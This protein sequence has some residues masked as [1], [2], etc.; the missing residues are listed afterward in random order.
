MTTTVG[1]PP[2][3]TDLFNENEIR[4]EGRDKVNGKMQYTA[5]IHLPNMLWSAY[6]TSPHAYARIKK[7]DTTAAK[8]VKGV[9]AV[10]T[11]HDIGQKRFG[12][13]IFDWPVLCYDVVRFIGDRVAAIAAET[14][15]AADEAARL[16]EVE[17]E[18]LDPVLTPAN[19]VRADAP[20]LHPEFE[21]YH[22]LAY[23]NKPK[24]QRP[25]PNLQTQVIIEKGDKDRARSSRR[26][27]ACSS[28]CSRRRVNTAATSNRTR[29]WCGSTRTRP[30]TCSRRTSRRLRCA[31]S[32]R[33]SPGSRS[34]RSSSRRARSAVTSAARGSRSTSTRVIFLPR[35]RGVRSGTSTSTPRSCS[36]ST[37]ATR[38][39]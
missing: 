30:S 27:T 22:Y 7:I 15:E 33:T 13:Q 17:Y 16:V 34:K 21:H 24:P 6:T 14:R 2:S 36:A 32:S 3:A 5:D 1:R 4:D 9:K 12:R 37:C 28:T 19:A 25:H 39:R 23:V 38:R 31:V 29:P 8:A 35:R 11:W 26:R 20:V 10:L 18:E